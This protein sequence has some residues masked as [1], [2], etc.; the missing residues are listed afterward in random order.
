MIPIL[1]RFWKPLTGAA[2]LALVAWQIHAYGERREQEGRDAVQALWDA[3]EKAAEA[4]HEQ[5]LQQVEDTYNVEIQDLKVRLAGALARPSTRVIRVPVE[6]VC[7]AKGPEDAGV[8]ESGPGERLLELDD[9]GY[10]SFR[11]WLYRYAG[12]SDHGD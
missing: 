11:D 6:S 10:P 12:A 9:P 8:P 4:R 2:L 1:L 7:P 5:K 3:A